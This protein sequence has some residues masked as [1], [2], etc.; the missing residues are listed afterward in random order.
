MA[1]QL[2]PGTNIQLLLSPW[3]VVVD[4]VRVKIYKCLCLVN[5]VL[6][7]NRVVSCS[8]IMGAWITNSWTK[9]NVAYRKWFIFWQV[10]RA[11]RLI[12]G[13]LY[14]RV[15]HEVTADPVID[16]HIIVIWAHMSVTLAMGHKMSPS[17]KEIHIITLCIRTR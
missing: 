12:E 8:S 5:Y 9:T 7:Y 16:H 1:S 14:I 11:G 6:R 15:A 17:E 3:I 13:I 4:T 10:F 2:K